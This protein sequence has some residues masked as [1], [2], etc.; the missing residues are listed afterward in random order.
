LVE[1]GSKQ[2]AEEEEDG[3]PF[4]RRESDGSLFALQ[5][6]VSFGRRGVLKN[7]K[8]AAA[9]DIRGFR[10]WVISPFQKAPHDGAK[11]KGLFWFVA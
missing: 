11:I 3:N 4:C 1:T 7:T 10:G 2:E 8:P 6:T 9:G 5:C